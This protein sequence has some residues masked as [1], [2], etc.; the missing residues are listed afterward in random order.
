[1]IPPIL[2]D[3]VLSYNEMNHNFFNVWCRYQWHSKSKDSLDTKQSNSENWNPWALAPMELLNCWN[4][5]E[6]N[7]SKLNHWEL[8]RMELSTRPD[9]MTYPVLEKSSTQPSF[10]P[11]TL[12]Q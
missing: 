3:R 8:A 9:V 11:M 6:S 2:W 12:E 4:T 10:S 7:C 1:M 5:K